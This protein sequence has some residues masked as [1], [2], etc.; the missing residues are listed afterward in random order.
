MSAMAVDKRYTVDGYTG[1]ARW[2][3][4]VVAVLVLALLG[5]G[6][7]MTHG[8]LGIERLFAA[9]QWHKTLGTLLWLLMLVRVGVRWRA[10]PPPLPQSVAPTRARV[11]H[12]VHGLLYAVLLVMPVTGWL[13]VSASPLP[14]PISLLGLFEIPSLR[15]LAEMQDLERLLWFARLQILHHGLA[16]LLIALVALHIAGA[17][18]HGRVVL[19]RMSLRGRRA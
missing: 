8:A 4:A 11:A 2:L 9:Y 10:V 15:W 7:V 18:S 1:A 5:L 6:L 19:S 17:F 14:F 12:S 16:W 3:H 13:M